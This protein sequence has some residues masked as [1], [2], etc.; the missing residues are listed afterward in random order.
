MAGPL[1]KDRYFLRL[2]SNSG[3]AAT[4]RSRYNHGGYRSYMLKTMLSD[5]VNISPTVHHSSEKIGKSGKSE[6][7][8]IGNKTI[9]QTDYQT[10]K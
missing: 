4:L 8:K 2:L 3:T 5:I 7:R 10:K 6:E 1:K 9:R